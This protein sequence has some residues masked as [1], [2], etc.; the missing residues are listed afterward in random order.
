MT[1]QSTAKNEINDRFYFFRFVL[2]LFSSFSPEI[3]SQLR[4]LRSL[5]NGILLF[6]LA[7]AA[8]QVP[9]YPYLYSSLERERA[10]AENV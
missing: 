6:T 9:S 8:A 4:S 7:P 1:A 3:K 5:P 2:F 10:R